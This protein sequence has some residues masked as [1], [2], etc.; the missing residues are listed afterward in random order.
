MAMSDYLKPVSQALL[1]TSRLRQGVGI[2]FWRR[3]LTTKVASSFLLLSFVTVAAVGGVAF[4]S[5]REALKQAAYNQL[6]VTATLKKQ[7][8]D[9]WL[10]ACG[11]DFLLI[12]QFPDVQANLKILLSHEP[13]DAKYQLAYDIL[14]E[15][16]QNIA[17]LKPKF[18]EISLLDRSNRIILSTDKV[19]EG[20]YEIATTLTYFEA[21]E[22]G[23]TFSPAFYRSPKTGKPAV[24]YAAPF[25]DAA[26]VRQGVIS[27]ELN[28]TRIDQIVREKTGLGETGETYLVGS[29]AGKNT[30]IS[31]QQSEPQKLPEEPHSKGIDGAMQG[32][33]GSGLYL[34]YRRVPVIGVYRWLNEQDLALLVELSQAEAFEPARRL[35]G[36]I[37]LVGLI[38]AG[39]LF[40]GVNWLARQLTLSRQQLENYSRQLEQK[41]QEAEAAN[42]AKSKFLANMS[43]ELRTPLNAILGFTQ[44]L[45]RASSINPVQLQHLAIISRS[46]EHLLTLINDV[47]EMSKI[48]AGRITLNESSFDLYRLLNSLEEMLRIKADAKGLHL[49]F[50]LSPDVPQSVKTDEGK[51]RQ[52]LINLLGNGIKFTQTGSVVLRVR[53]GTEDWG[54]RTGNAGVRRQPP[55]VKSRQARKSGSSR[56]P[57][58]PAEQSPTAIGRQLIA[59]IE[60]SKLK[61]QNLKAKIQNT[62]RAEQS[63]TKLKPQTSHCST[64]IF[65]V[66]DTGPGIESADL[67]RLFEPFVQTQSGQ[68]KQQGTGL[69]LAISR[70][71]VRLLGGDLTVNSTPGQGTVFAFDIRICPADL[72]DIATQQPTRQVI[73]LAPNQPRYR[74]LIVEDKWENRQLLV[75]LLEPLG[76]AIREAANGQEGVDLWRTWQPHLIWMDMRMPVMDGYEATKQ[77][78]SHL[79]GHATVII[80]L[81]A[82]AFE[83]SRSVI[84]AVGCDDFVRKPFRE[85]VIFEKMAQ[86]LGVQYIYANGSQPSAVSSQQSEQ[87]NGYALRAKSL[88]VMSDQWVADLRQAAIQVDADLIFQLVDQIPPAHITLAQGLA[89]LARNF[90]FDEII[91]LTQG[92]ANV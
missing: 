43:H 26:G 82:S 72:A 73:G 55:D 71:F 65:E 5:A 36:T 37:M 14:S 58:L 50:D 84:L 11:R 64:L 10:K 53:T 34:N 46:G 51:L 15:Y 38:S 56:Q 16:L 88:S 57:P 7:A 59:R 1:I 90:C 12:T 78:K 31:R 91:E 40:V 49:I 32:I 87:A 8:I 80:A 23:E 54:L 83:E 68:K 3:N 74:I 63:S 85:K 70:Q 69:G 92:E 25:R 2:K 67:E 77:I 52:I 18:V 4:V 60:N 13:G 19:R 29:L 47:L 76:L 35:A 39:M 41:A 86:H 33:T 17:E 44:L 75:K 66:S 42:R 89:E 27:A 62:L 45:T 48:E 24:T 22:S 20:K 21:I 81:T 79:R 9:R 30:F 6:N 61:I 28:L